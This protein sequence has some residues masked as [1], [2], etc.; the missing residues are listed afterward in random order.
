MDATRTAGTGAAATRAALGAVLGAAVGLL[1][2]CPVAAASGSGDEI[3]K[4]R[5]FATDLLIREQYEDAI[6]TFVTIAE[7]TPHDAR[8]HYDVAGAMVFVRMWP[9]AIPRIE[10]AIALDPG[11]TLYHEMAAMTYLQLQDFPHAFEATRNGARLGDMKA[12]YALAGM[13]EHG[14]GTPASQPQALQWL[15]RAARAGHMSAMEAMA[16][17]YRDGLYGQVPDQARE[18]AWRQELDRAMAR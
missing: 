5:A 1:L 15:E 11:N 18:R 4:M 8:S 13:Y 16:R 17:V 14:R 3:A 7:R 2:A 6:A 10:Q 9:E 12:M